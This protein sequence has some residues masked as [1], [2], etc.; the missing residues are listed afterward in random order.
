MYGKKSM[1]TKQYLHF[2][3]YHLTQVKRG[4][5]KYPYDKARGIVSN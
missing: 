4:V 5:L 1:N 2:K 3:F